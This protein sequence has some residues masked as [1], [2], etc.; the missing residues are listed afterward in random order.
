MNTRIEVIEDAIFL[1]YFAVK[2]THTAHVLHYQ[3]LARVF[4]HFTTF[5]QT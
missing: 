2:M 3:S 4:D 5:M 1:W